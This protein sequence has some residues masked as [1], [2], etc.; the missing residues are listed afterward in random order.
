MVIKNSR[1]HDSHTWLVKLPLVVVS[2]SQEDMRKLSHLVDQIN[3]GEVSINFFLLII[4]SKLYYDISLLR[5][6]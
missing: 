3:S 5:L 1:R 6:S 2:N 4:C